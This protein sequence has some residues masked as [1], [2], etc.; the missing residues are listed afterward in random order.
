MFKYRLRVS[1]AF[2]LPPFF[3]R[4]MIASCK[5]KAAEST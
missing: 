2:G 5:C 3:V 1:A 4:P